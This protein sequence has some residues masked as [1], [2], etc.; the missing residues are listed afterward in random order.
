MR[1]GGVGFL[2]VVWCGAIPGA[3][4]RARDTVIKDML[5]LM[6]RAT[7]VL[8]GVTDEKT[9][10][11]ATPRLKKIG[12]ERKAISVRYKK[13]KLSKEQEDKLKKKYRDEVKSHQGKL[14]KEMARV[15]KIPG[16]KKA[17][18]L[19]DPKEEKKKTE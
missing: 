1:I 13:L 14:L 9:L 2:L 16:G 10:K 11:A 12:L 19:L 3:D 6:K 7:K 5:G 17:L 8:A 18:K 4:D 15:D